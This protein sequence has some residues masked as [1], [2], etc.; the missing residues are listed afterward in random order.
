MNVLVIYGSR[1]GG[2]AEVAKKIGQTLTRAGCIVEVINAKKNPKKIEP[3]DLFIIGSGMRADKWTKETLVFLK[4]TH[5]IYKNK[6]TALFVSCQ[7]ADR[8]EPEIRDKAKKQ[9][10][11]D[12]A[13]RYALK[14]IACGFFGGFLDFSQIKVNC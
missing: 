10:L 11:Q 12:T 14:P 13:E 6:K 3:Y 2:T 4:K 8:E 5:N 1:W 9:Y 7:M